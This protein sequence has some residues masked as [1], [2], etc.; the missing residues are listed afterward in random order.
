MGL[1][2]GGGGGGGGG[3]LLK[4]RLCSYI[5]IFFLS[6]TDPSFSPIALR[7]AKTLWSFG[8]SECIRVKGHKTQELLPFAEMAEEHGCIRIHLK[9]SALSC[10]DVLCVIL[11]PDQPTLL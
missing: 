1:G 6:R 4:E 11:K 2:G 3:C 10:Q 7:T 9:T 8:C 5:I